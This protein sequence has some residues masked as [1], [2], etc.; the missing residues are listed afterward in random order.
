MDT[1]IVASF[2]RGVVIQAPGLKPK[3]AYDKAVDLGLTQLCQISDLLIQASVPYIDSS[4][5]IDIRQCELTIAIRHTIAAE[6]KQPLADGEPLRLAI[7]RNYVT[8]PVDIVRWRD[9][10][11]SKEH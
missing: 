2:Y 8:L 7:V 4:S 1:V 9:S 11:F 5:L 10:L 6:Q 3:L